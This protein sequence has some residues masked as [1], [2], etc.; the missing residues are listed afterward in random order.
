MALT[1]PNTVP[2]ELVL[3]P[4]VSDT[5]SSAAAAASASA[6]ILASLWAR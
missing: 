2:V 6:L 1:E 5:P 4:M 3:A